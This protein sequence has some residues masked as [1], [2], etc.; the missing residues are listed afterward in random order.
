MVSVGHHLVCK[1]ASN[2]Q[3]GH[4]EHRDMFCREEIGFAR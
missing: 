3:G 1:H 4:K 2:N